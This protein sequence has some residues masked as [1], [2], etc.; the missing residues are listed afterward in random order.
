MK[1]NPIPETQ[2][3]AASWDEDAQ[4][5]RVRWSDGVVVGES[6]ARAATEAIVGLGKGA[7]PLLVDMTDMGKLD[8]GAREHFKVDKGGTSAF[9]LLVGSPVTKMLAN[10]FMRTDADETPVRMFTDEQTAIAWLHQGSH[11]HD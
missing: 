3:F 2:P 9:A 11:E 10:F 5:L 8:R 6:E 1:P 7:A 4:I